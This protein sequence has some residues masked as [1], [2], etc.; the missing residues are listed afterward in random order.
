MSAGPPTRTLTSAEFEHL[1]Q[2]AA[3][4]DVYREPRLFTLGELV[5]AGQEIGIDPRSVEEVYAEYRQRAVQSQ[6]PVRQPPLGASTQLY[7]RGDVLQVIVRPVHYRNNGYGV[8]MLG[9]SGMLVLP[10]FLVDHFTWSLPIAAAVAALG[11]FLWWRGTRYPGHELRLFR[12][13]SGVLMEFDGSRTKSYPLIAGQVHARLATEVEHSEHS[14][15][16]IDYVALD[17][18]T[19]THGLLVGF[20]HAERAWVV[21]EIESWLGR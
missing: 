18:A 21:D 11:G 8:A 16:T 4:R 10:A 20:S 2:R 15:R 5:S 14:T 3:E 9:A 6:R 19:Q 7:K 12:D 17:H 1:L 13:G